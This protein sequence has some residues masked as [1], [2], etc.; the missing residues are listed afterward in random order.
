LDQ[1]ELSSHW[2]PELGSHLLT[3]F[4]EA[5]QIPP[6][7]LESYLSDIRPSY[8]LLKRYTLLAALKI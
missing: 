3:P 8:E 5:L 6:D 1:P 4:F 7:A 2:Q